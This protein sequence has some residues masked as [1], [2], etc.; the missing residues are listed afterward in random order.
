MIKYYYESS[1]LNYLN[2]KI[3]NND[4]HYFSKLI[5]HFVEGMLSKQVFEYIEIQ[6]QMKIF[7][8]NNSNWKLKTRHDQFDAELI[9]VFFMGIDEQDLSIYTRDDFNIVDFRIRN[10]KLLL[11][12]VNEIRANSFLSEI[13]FQ[14]NNKIIFLNDNLE[15]ISEIKSD[16][17][18]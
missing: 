16:D 12:E 14:K 9:D 4:Q 17:Y 18:K 11:N 6:N 5:N 2:Q 8:Q 10:Y 15:V 3:E 13:I 7:I 1:L